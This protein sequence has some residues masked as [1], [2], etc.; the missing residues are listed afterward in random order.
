MLNLCKDDTVN[1]EFM[2]ALEP[3]YRDKTVVIFSDKGLAHN[4]SGSQ[5]VV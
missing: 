5:S 3:Q 4:S 1:P 2:E